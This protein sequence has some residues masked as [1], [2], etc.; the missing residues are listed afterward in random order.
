MG[1]RVFRFRLGKVSGAQSF[2]FLGWS[3]TV[4]G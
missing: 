3:T 1:F 4:A 2:V